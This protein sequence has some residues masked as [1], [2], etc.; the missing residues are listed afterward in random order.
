MLTARPDREDLTKQREALTDARA[1][2]ADT[3]STLSLEAALAVKVLRRPKGDPDLVA[4]YA[5]H[6]AV[7]RAEEGVDL[8]VLD[9]A[10]AGG[11]DA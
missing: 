11:A 2:L 5:A 7:Q 6:R 1:A 3:L 8:A 9:L 10:T 4:V